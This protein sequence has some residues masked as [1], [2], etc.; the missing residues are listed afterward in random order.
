[1]LKGSL[2]SLETGFVFR[3]PRRWNLSQFAFP[4]AA[5]DG[6][7]SIAI[8]AT[9]LN[10]SVTDPTAWAT[11][12][13][14]LGM[15]P[16]GLPGQ[17]LVSGK[18]SLGLEEAYSRAGRLGCLAPRNLSMHKCRAWPGI[19]AQGMFGRPCAWASCPHHLTLL[20]NSCSQKKNSHAVSLTDGIATW[21]LYFKKVNSRAN[22]CFP[23]CK[24]LPRMLQHLIPV[25]SLRQVGPNGGCGSGSCSHVKNRE[26]GAWSLGGRLFQ[27]WSGKA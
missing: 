27:H 2:T 14:N 25:F 6:L 23:I 15:V 13:N 9:Q 19:Y 8:D 11:A 12:M 10:M 24:A 21:I 4:P 1:M 26:R 22:I 17:Q 5:A 3:H 16:V 20:L 7:G 18:L